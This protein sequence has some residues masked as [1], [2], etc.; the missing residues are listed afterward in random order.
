MR[1]S[2][3]LSLVLSCISRVSY[4]HPGRRGDVVNVVIYEC[5]L[6]DF[7]GDQAFMG[8]VEDASHAGLHALFLA[9]FQ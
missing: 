2:P 9:G 7:V 5:R 4:T 6:G 3:R 8:Q 1:S